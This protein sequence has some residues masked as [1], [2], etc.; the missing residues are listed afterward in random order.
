MTPQVLFP[1][2]I[3]IH[4]HKNG[5]MKKRLFL[6]TALILF[7]LLSSCSAEDESVYF[8]MLAHG[9]KPRDMQ[10]RHRIFHYDGKS[11]YSVVYTFEDTEPLTA[12]EVHYLYYTPYERKEGQ[13]TALHRVDLIT[14]EDIVYNEME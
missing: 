13:P 9:D 6:I 2:R 5:R 1:P 11:G 3:Y 8:D 4:R 10:E 12:I 7:L 14:G